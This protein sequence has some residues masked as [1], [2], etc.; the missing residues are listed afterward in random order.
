MH[1]EQG[2]LS[3]GVMLRRLCFGRS[4]LPGATLERQ[5]M[6]EE[7]QCISEAPPFSDVRPGRPDLLSDE[8][9]QS[10]QGLPSAVL[11]L[12]HPDDE[13]IGTGSRLPWLGARTTL[14]YA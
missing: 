8:D 13:T 4:L 7:R 6:S 12:A 10:S 2:I 5:C 1:D 11:V 9:F 14:I 3:P